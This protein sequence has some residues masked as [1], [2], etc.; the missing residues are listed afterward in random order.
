MCNFLKF[1]LLCFWYVCVA[2]DLKFFKF[3]TFEPLI[4]KLSGVLMCCISVHLVCLCIEL[5]H[6]FISFALIVFECSICSFGLNDL[7]LNFVK[8]ENLNF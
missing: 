5:C 3:L 7:A 2:Y 1:V 6:T 8:C 4:S